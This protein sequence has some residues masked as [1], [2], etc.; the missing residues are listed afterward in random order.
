MRL[1]RC[2]VDNFGKISDLDLDFA[3]GLNVINQPNAWG[4]ST[5]A[6]FLKAMFYGFDSKK[7]AG[8]VAKERDLYRPWQGGTFGGELDFETAGKSYRVVRTFGKSEKGDEY[9]LYDLDTML[10]SR[11]FSGNLGGELFDLDAAS[12]KRSIYIAQNDCVSESS[13]AIN[14]KLGNLVENTNDINNFETALT[15]IKNRMNSLSPDRVTGSIKKRK[16]MITGL[17]QKLK[18]FESAGSALAQLEEKIRTKQEQKKEMLGYRQEYAQALKV[19]SEESA[20]KELKERYQHLLAEAAEKKEKLASYQSLFP[21]GVPS[22]EAFAG[23][24]GLLQK[25]EEHKTTTANFELSQGELDIYQQLE[26]MFDRAVPTEERIDAQIDKLTRLTKARKE[27]AELESKVQYISATLERKELDYRPKK[28]G[29]KLPIAL[30]TVLEIIGALVAVVPFF[31][32]KSLGLFP[33]AQIAG[34]CVIVLGLIVLVAGAI[35]DNKAKRWNEENE[36]EKEKYAKPVEELEER[37]V[38]LNAS[39]RRQEDEAR[40]YLEQFHVFCATEN[41]QAK[42]FELKSLLQDYQRFNER[43]QKLK[44]SK[45]ASDNIRREV[46]DFEQEYG[47]S[48]GENKNEKL[49]DF[50]TGATEYRMAKTACEEAVRKQQEFENTYNPK[51]LSEITHCPYSLDELNNMIAQIDGKVEEIRI[52]IE[53]LTHQMEDLQKQLDQKEEL[54][55]ELERNL[56]LQEQELHTYEVIRLTGEFLTGA[57]EQ[58]TSRYM[59]PIS[60]A[61][62]KYYG[63]LSGSQEKNWQVDA[64]IEVKIKEHGQLREAKYFSAG[65]RDLL[66]ICMR[67]ALVEAMY[68]EEKPFLILDDPFVNLDDDKLEQGKK[69]LSRLSGEYQTIYFTCHESRVVE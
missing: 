12:F 67:L 41:L 22:E 36:K 47:L 56:A 5:L 33:V 51:D 6:A 68:Q 19:A 2:H 23:V 27:V 25:L 28:T 52:F 9:H 34:A 14:A 57:K 7:E 43:I 45:E 50:R 60:N 42:L 32:P 63:W 13:D 1:L 4:K 62:E 65:Y 58:F 69:M 20:K 24:A 44:L 29:R 18:S 11:D 48:L 38:E 46:L 21:K 66:G 35:S 54:E 17:E 10:E 49:L 30:A 40:D 61:F 37:I 59:A 16:G 31:L 64:H 26:K 53:Q 55:Q 39:I 3:R 15:A 8:A